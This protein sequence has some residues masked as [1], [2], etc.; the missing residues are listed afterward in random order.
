MCPTSL[1]LLLV[2]RFTPA[3]YYTRHCNTEHVLL[4]CSAACLICLIISW[5][6]G[7]NVFGLWKHNF[8]R[9]ILHFSN[10]TDSVCRMF[11]QKSWYLFR[12]TI[13]TMA[14]RGEAE[15]SKLKKNIEEQLDRLMQQ[16]KDLEDSKY[17]ALYV[18]L[19]VILCIHSVTLIWTRI[20]SER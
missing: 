6:V 13:N 18:K 9:N 3:S 16:L 12:D 7:V 19:S 14:S 5:Y 4:S 8:W 1:I 15:T 20:L 10:T 11:R 17:I 2:L